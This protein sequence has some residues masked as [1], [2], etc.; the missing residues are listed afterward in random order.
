M[1]V[2]WYSAL[3]VAEFDPILSGTPRAG[4]TLFTV[5]PPTHTPYQTEFVA[6]RF[7]RWNGI[8]STDGRQG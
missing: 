1:D 2:G 8:Y 5:W 4:S 7:G 6:I 3:A